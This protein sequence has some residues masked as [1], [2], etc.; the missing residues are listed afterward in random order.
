MKPSNSPTASSSVSG[1]AALWFLM[2]R[3]EHM[4]Q[5]LPKLTIA[6]IWEGNSIKKK[7][8]LFYVCFA[9]EHIPTHRCQER[10]LG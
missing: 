3:H 10:M 6:L 4:H 5:E 7:E 9:L 8:S 2:R 1:A